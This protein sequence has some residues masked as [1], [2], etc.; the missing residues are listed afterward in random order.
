MP[1]VRVDILK[2]KT[3]ERKKMLMDI[4]HDALISTIGIPQDDRLQLLLEHLPDNF[5]MPN[6]K[7]TEYINIDITMYP[8]RTKEAKVNLIRTIMVEFEKSGYPEAKS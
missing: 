2:G 5:C 4:I 3:R 7:T 1:K 8:G 6:S